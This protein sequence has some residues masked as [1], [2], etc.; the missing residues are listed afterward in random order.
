VVEDFWHR[1]ADV[2]VCTTIV[3]NGVDIPS[4]NT[5]IVDHAHEL[6]L[7]QLHQ[8]RGRVGR[9][10]Q[11]AYAYLFYPGTVPLT[12]LALERL[13]TVMENADLGAGYRIAMRDL[14][15]RGAGTFLGHRQSGHQGAVGYDLYVRLVAEAVASM[16]GEEL[17]P[18]TPVVSIDLPVSFALE[19]SYVPSE[20]DRLDL[21]RRIAQARSEEDL[22][23]LTDE[24]RD[25]FGPLPPLAETLMAMARLKLVAAERK[26]EEVMTRRSPRTGRREVVIRPIV[27]KASEEVRL[28]RLP[29]RPRLVGRELVLEPSSDPIGLVREVLLGLAG[30]RS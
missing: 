26:I 16:K 15:L 3:E 27:L 19:P 6:G 23:R 10:D 18:T 13:R 2:L 22:A 8:L 30:S 4:V 17:P 12:E 28:R 25:R 11:R 7:A 24:L 14:E 20:A 1:R 5:L 29:G 9:S 21:Y